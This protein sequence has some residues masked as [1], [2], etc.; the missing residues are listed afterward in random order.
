MRRTRRRTSQKMHL[1]E[2]WDSCAQNETSEISKSG[3]SGFQGLLCAEQ[4]VGNLKKWTF[5]N[6]GTPVRRT[7]R[8]KFQK[9]TFRISGSPVRRTRRRKSEKIDCQEVWDSCAQ[10]KTSEI[11][12]TALSGSPA[13]YRCSCT[14]AQASG[15]QC[16]ADDGGRPES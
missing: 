16:S 3:C 1:Q 12:K 2:F 14:A 5:R 9:W 10:N 11:S 8:R 15:D 13:R 7:R 6:Y 4:D